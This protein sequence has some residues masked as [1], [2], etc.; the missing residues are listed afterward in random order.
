MKRNLIIFA[1]ASVTLASCSEAAYAQ[2]LPWSTSVTSY[3][4]DANFSWASNTL[5]PDQPLKFELGGRQYDLGSLHLDYS[6]GSDLD[7]GLP[8]FGLHGTWAWSPALT[9]ADSDGYRTRGMLGIDLTGIYTQDGG[10]ATKNI[11]GRV[12]IFV[13]VKWQVKD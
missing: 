10:W 5:L 3:W 12:G 8:A 1:L 2:Q 4:G 9:K 6:L 7:R 11:S 13:G